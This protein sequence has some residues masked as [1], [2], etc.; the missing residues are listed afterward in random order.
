V[1]S[2]PVS[3]PPEV[4]YLKADQ[5]EIYGQEVNVFITY[6][7]ADAAGEEPHTQ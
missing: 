7:A 1:A 2:Q 5:S 4:I 6:P 3:L